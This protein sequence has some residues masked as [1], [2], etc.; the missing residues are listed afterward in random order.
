MQAF[1]SDVIEAVRLD[2]LRD[3]LRYLV[4]R[5]LDPTSPCNAD[6]PCAACNTQKTTE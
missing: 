5:R 1:M 2:N 6:D 3:R 4:D